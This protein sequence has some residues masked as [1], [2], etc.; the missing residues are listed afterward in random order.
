[1]MTVNSQ[2]NPIRTKI[3]AAVLLIATTLLP[4]P[5]PMEQ[6]GAQPP[7]KVTP[8]TINAEINSVL[9][10]SALEGAGAGV[11][12]L[13]LAT[14]KVIYAHNAD[15][16]LIPASNMKIITAAAALDV[17][18]PEYRFKT[19]V[20]V[21]SFK[22]GVIEG[23]LY[24]KGYGDPILMDEQLWT[25][26]RDVAYRGVVQ[27]TG[28][29]LADD[30]YFDD[31]R[32]GRGWGELGPEAFNAPIGALSLNFN[33]FVIT[34]V[35]G[36][37]AGQPPRVFLM[38]PDKHLEVTN[39]AQTSAGGAA[40]IRVVEVADKVN[41][42]DVIGYV[43]I[44]SDITTVRRNVGDPGLY[45]A[46]SFEAYLMSWG[47]VT[48][49][50]IGRKQAPKSAW[51]LNTYQ[52]PPLSQAIWSMGKISNNFVSEQIL[53]TMGAEAT[54][55]GKPKVGT[56][57]GGVQVVQKYLNGLGIAPDSYVMVDGSGLSR[58]NRLT[59]RQLATVLS[60]VYKNP[61]YRPE[62]IASLGVGGVDGT[63]EDR[64]QNVT[65]R[66]RVRAKTGHLNG[67]NAISGYLETDSGAMLAF[68]IILNDFKG[69]HSSV[70]RL[71][72]RILATLSRY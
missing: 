67:V 13:D 19:E 58:L 5:A 70:E 55:E 69:Y 40:R 57:E 39:R 27:L 62:F 7:A 53:K 10:S 52:S 16:R 63:V 36:P 59:P 31:Q 8:E 68:S 65:F 42:Y 1:M 71:E 25:I 51:L 46:G 30:F 37:R 29:V 14:G 47:I 44:G 24:L 22:N 56:F 66:R 3:A 50:K 2:K 48:P 20:Y 23:N 6:A 72:E 45:T 21:D 9:N 28:S 34:A 54:P 49:G 12:A 26:A 17:L 61:S 4:F 41:A 35:P 64:F 32:Y 38:P 18:K 11:V 43:P 15:R 60:F 33:T